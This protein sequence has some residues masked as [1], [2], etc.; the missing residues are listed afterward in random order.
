[1]SARVRSDYSEAKSP[2]R[3]IVA[4]FVAGVGAMLVL[5]IAAPIVAK[6]GLSVPEAEATP[7]ERPAQQLA[8]LDLDTVRAQLADADASLRQRAAATDE[9]V[10]RLH[11]L[12]NQ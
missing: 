2:V 6:A 9:T 5:G 10:Q 8:P 7:V 3:S 4:S 1:M 12:A 11:R